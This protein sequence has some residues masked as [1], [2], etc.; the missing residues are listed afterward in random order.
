MEQQIFFYREQQ[1]SVEAPQEPTILYNWAV[2]RQAVERY[3]QRH[4]QKGIQRTLLYTEQQACQVYRQQ[5]STDP[6][7]PARGLFPL[8]LTRCKTER[9][10][11]ARLQ[12]GI[13]LLDYNPGSYAPLTIRDFVRANGFKLAAGRFVLQEGVIYRISPN[14]ATEKRTKLFRDQNWE[15]M[16]NSA[17]RFSL[18]LWGR[19]YSPRGSSRS[20]QSLSPTSLLLDQDD[21]RLAI[22]P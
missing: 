2:S 7:F 16:L 5:L 9:D 8:T 3:L 20:V 22:A 21:P 10:L 19:A 4:Q 17:T 12:L 11:M 6:E 14:G 13:G 15:A 18:G 1:V